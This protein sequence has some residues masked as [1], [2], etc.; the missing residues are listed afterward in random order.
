VLLHGAL[1]RLENP[2]F[3]AGTRGILTA[4]AEAPA[5][6]VVTGNAATALAQGTGAE[7]ESKIGLVSTGGM[8]SLAVIEGKKLPGIEALRE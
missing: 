7:L 1:G 6:G 8:A 3:A 5:F 4:L 2:A